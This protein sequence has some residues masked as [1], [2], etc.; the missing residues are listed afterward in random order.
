MKNKTALLSN[1]LTIPGTQRS[2]RLLT[3]LDKLI[4][5]DLLKTVSSVLLVLVIIIVSQ[6]FIRVLAQAIQGN[7]ANDTVLSLLGF[8]TIV[9]ASTFFP[10]ALFMSVLMVFGRMYRDQEIAAIASAGG[11]MGTLYRAVFWLLIP[12]SLASAGLSMYAAPWAE[13][14]SQKMMHHDEE[15]AD[16]RSISPGRFSEYRNGELIFYAEALDGGNGKM[17]NVFVQ[18][19]QGLRSAIANAEFGHIENLPGGSYLILENGERIIGIA[20]QKDFSI[21][22]FQEYAVLIERKATDLIPVKHGVASATLIRSKNLHDI[23]EL[24]DRLSSPIGIILLGFLAVPLSRMSPRGGVYGNLL[25]AFGIYFIYSNLLRVNHSWML[26]GKM[27]V[28]LGYIWIDCLLILLG[29]G[30]LTRFYGFRWIYDQFRKR[31]AG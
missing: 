31:F 9:V 13:A 30:L 16:I 14:Q 15:N 2:F 21:E 17:R 22:R 10:A 29:L 24:Q 1:K 7:I 11:G 25:M 6:K 28:L 18:N 20:G 27:P 12:L 23:T 4:I 8:K 19:K 3:V 26:K 5:V